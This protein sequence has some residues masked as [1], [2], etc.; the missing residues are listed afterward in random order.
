MS[1]WTGCVTSFSFL[2]TIQEIKDPE[3]IKCDVL[4]IGNQNGWIYYFLFIRNYVQ[5]INNYI[6][7]FAYCWVSVVNGNI[8][9][10]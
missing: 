3:Y 6:N 7:I 8:N 1:T 2:I 10:F 4:C 9:T 5:Y